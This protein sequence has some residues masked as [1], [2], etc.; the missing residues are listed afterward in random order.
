MIQLNVGNIDRVIR[1]LF[2]VTLVVLAATGVIGGW[3]FLGLAVTL[4]G[5][6]AFCPLYSL[7]GL[8]T[9]WR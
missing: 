7:L 5:L 1:I 3:G 2:G 4:T 9:T 6:V 8:R